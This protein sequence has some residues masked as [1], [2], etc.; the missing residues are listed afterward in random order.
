MLEENNIHVVSIPPNC[1]NRLQPM[2]LSVN[3]SVKEFIQGKF[4][5][6]FSEQIQDQLS[7]G[8]REYTPVDLKMSTCIEATWSS[9]VCESLWLHNWKQ[10][11][12]RKWCQSCWFV[13]LIFIGCSFM[14]QS[15][16]PSRLHQFLILYR[17]YNNNTERMLWN[18][19]GEM[20]TCVKQ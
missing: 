13:M 10:V 12:C 6:W 1:T 3:K 11:Y 5:D 19:M 4:R 14:L 18:R 7:E 20:L 17:F 2:D 15:I 9:L 8:K 16:L